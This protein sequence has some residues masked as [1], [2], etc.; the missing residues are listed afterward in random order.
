MKRVKYHKEQ[1]NVKKYFSPEDIRRIR[2]SLGLTQAEAGELLGGGPRAFAKYEKGTIEPAASVVN[3]L[4]MLQANPK[5]LSTLSGRKVVPINNEV[6]KPFE[7][8]GQHVAT[9][10]DRKFTNLVRRLLTAEAY[11]AELPMHGIHVA[12]VISA[13]DAGED[14]R[15]E[16]NGG[17]DHTPYLPSRLSMFQLKATNIAPAE[18]GADVLTSAG[19]AQPMIRST[20]E[21]G[22]TYI[23]LCARSYTQK[24]IVKREASM[25]KSLINTGLSVSRAQIQFR[26]ADQIAGWVNA[27]PPVVAWL[28]EQTQPGLVGPFRVWT[29]WAGRH[30][31][32][33]SPWVEDA[34]LAAFRERLRALI[35]PLRGIARVVGL[36]GTG[37]SRLTL[38]A[39]AQT[40]AEEKISMCL[41]DLVLY[42][43]ESEVG[44]TTIK[45]YVQNLVDSG[46]RAICV[47]DRCTEE[48]HKDLAAMVKRQSSRLSLIT[49]DHEIP[50]DKNFPADTLL[51]DCAAEVVI[52]KI[53]G[54]IAPNISG[55]DQR[56]VVKFAAGLPQLA[57]LVGQA[58]VNEGFLAPISDDALVDRIV[59]GRNPH[60][61]QLLRDAAMLLGAFG[62]IGI[63]APLDNDLSEVAKLSRGRT[64][65]DLRAAFEELSRR[66]V[67]QLHGRLVTLQPRPVALS[68]AEH[69]W[70][71]WSQ[72]HW[73][74][75]LAGSVSQHLRKRAAD[76]LSLLNTKLFATD[77][78]RHVCRLN[79]PFGSLKGLCAEGNTE[80]L[81]S[82][83]E[84][85]SEIVV[86]VL[87]RVLGSLTTKQL[88]SID[89]D[90]RRHLVWA[91]EKITFVA[92]T[93][94][95]GA[96]LLL[97]LAVAENETWGNNATG[98]FKSLFPVL[99]A[100]T[101]A[102]PEPRLQVIDDVIKGGDSARLSIVVDALREGAKTDFFS[103]SVGSEL[104]GGRAA[105]KPWTP[106]I[107]KEAFDY[108]KECANR[109]VSLAT[110]SDE[111]GAKARSALGSQFRMYI[112]RGLI[113]DVERWVK[114]VISAHPYWPQALD[115]LGDYLQYDAEGDEQKVEPRVRRLITDLTPHQ[116]A[117]R[118][119]F[120]VTE[121]PWDYPADE[122]LDFDARDK[123]QLEVIEGLASELVE[124]AT[125]L[126]PLLPQ[127]S[128]SNQRMAQHFGGAIARRAKDPLLWRAPMME[129]LQAV[130]E[131]ERNFALMSGF[132]AGLAERDTTAFEEFKQMASQHADFA[133]ALPLVC[134]IAGIRPEDIQIVCRALALK[135]IPPFAIS[136]WSLGGRLA[137]VPTAAVAPL[138]DQM[139]KMEQPYYSIAIHL[140]GMYVHGQAARLEDLRP[141]LRL[142]A[143]LASRRQKKGGGSQS[144]A[145]HF[146]VL[147]E[148]LLKKG[149]GDADACAVAMMLA[150]QLIANPSGD[151]ADLIKP[152]LPILL[153]D[154]SQIVWPLIGQGIVANKKKAWLLQMVLGDHYSFRHK[155]NSAILNV[156]LEM[157][158]AWCHAHPEAAPAFVAS[159]I[160]I[161]TT[162]NPSEGSSD[163]HP[164]TKRLLDE[165]GERGDVLSALI[166][167]MHTFGW[168]GSR[169]TYYAL[170]EQP[171]LSIESHPIGAVRRWAKEM[172]ADM[173]RQIESARNEDEEQ[174][175]KWDT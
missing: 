94:E 153:A 112:C 152:L 36:S 170:Y 150:K 53:L 151:G 101:A 2:E 124:D 138:F 105:L 169:T 127:L 86:R 13:P 64:T 50:P 7:V 55:E 154:F 8:T 89:G 28:L 87:E 43:V 84:V 60:E 119:R 32:E 9:L 117:D 168:T 116:L 16:W 146:E 134:S 172:L 115:S 72:E 66:R 156:P 44:T 142:A 74:E 130:P 18:A 65:D 90:V 157:L 121:M 76:Q 19:E 141:Q 69:Q 71:N 162:Q 4:R 166:A 88:Q 111:I 27:H 106:K 59:L 137:K 108:V 51:I 92:N 85:D 96:I 139:L 140:M 30:E 39:L 131:N 97:N 17:P 31:H 82:L 5:A 93:F 174:K 167:N 144:D 3:L 126:R 80:V 56:R 158:F 173:R 109:L 29:H 78:V 41:A 148:W 25:H 62:L 132:F 14:A 70:R 122:K 95:R 133:P 1:K 33:S 164:V 110:R 54:G 75:V 42:A 128:R 67:A 129:S 47:V 48:T 73:D 136:I 49:I 12:A 6:T 171:L 24:E 58:W 52:E 45:Q 120:L 103:R 26:D 149:S 11:N 114:K 77:I 175:A 83:S 20:L 68:L 118:V 38:E 91:L 100:N 57:R 81:S 61:P 113:D 159:V 145:H 143:S 15:I 40:E 23:M 147:M 160:P 98:Q 102:G 10:N 155:K 123:R 22:G 135:L 125:T 161:L 163:F 79:G 165:F 46:M 104:H 37:K 99:L 107:W 21:A 35:T 34:R 63:K